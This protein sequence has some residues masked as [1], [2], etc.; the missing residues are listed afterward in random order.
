MIGVTDHDTVAGLADAHEAGK[1]AGVDVVPGVELS[2]EQR[3]RDVH[4]LGYFVDPADR[5]LVEYLER[6][7]H[8]RIERAARIVELVR[9]EG[10]DLTIDEVLTQAG[11]GRVGRAHVARALVAAGAAASLAE[12]FDR[13]LGRSACCYVPK[14]APRLAEVVSFLAGSGAV[15]VIAHPSIGPRRLELGPLKKAGL[16]G[17]EYLHPEQSV[18]QRAYWRRRARAFGLAA[19]GGT[20]WHGATDAHPAALGSLSVDASV[21]DDLARRRSRRLRSVKAP[22]LVALEDWLMNRNVTHRGPVAS[23]RRRASGRP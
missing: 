20:D 9:R 19:T 4:V 23:S 6:L 11:M 13:F 1:A 10:F 17:V 7:K 12:A 16:A 3:G 2:A 18:G 8:L 5:V 15:P 14:P 21:A 22:S